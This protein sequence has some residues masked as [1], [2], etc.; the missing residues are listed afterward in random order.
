MKNKN[1][2]MV[3][4]KIKRVRIRTKMKNNLFKNNQV[5]NNLNKVLKNKSRVRMES[6][7]MKRKNHKRILIFMFSSKKKTICK[8]NHL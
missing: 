4:K 3:I 7:R 5:K 1:K 2:E 6:R 8:E